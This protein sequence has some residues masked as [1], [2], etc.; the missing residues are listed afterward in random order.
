MSVTTRLARWRPTRWR[1][2]RPGSWPNGPDGRPPYPA[3]WRAVLRA[4]WRWAVVLAG[5]AVLCVIPSVVAAVPV[6]G[7]AVSAAALRHRILASAGL[8]YEGYAET[9][10]NAGLPVLPDLGNVSRLLDGVTDQYVWYRSPAHW[11]ADTLTTAGEDDVYQVG[12]ETFLWNHAY[13]LLTRVVGAQPVRLPR[14]SDL[15]PPALARRLLRLAAPGDHLSRL[16]S[17]RIAGVDAAGLRL[18]PASPSTTVSAI[19][20]WADPASGL[21]VEVRIFARGSRHPLLVSNFLQ[22]ARHRAALA[23]LVPHPAPGIDEVTASESTLNGLLNGGRRHPWPPALGG[24]RFDPAP[25]GNF[26]GVAFYGSG[27][28]R[29]ALLPLPGR[30]GRRVVAAATAVGAAGFSAPDGSGLVV[31]TPLLTVVLATSRRFGGFTFLLAGPVTEA[32]LERAAGDLL[33]RIARLH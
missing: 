16:P 6:P 3:R 14:A 20:I 23:T 9:T 33:G 29:L 28:A 21:P 18:V 26:L 10:A 11:R 1:P 22:V 27:F 19:D 13:N 15:L 2:A 31:R 17:R 12:P 24:F 7:S 30:T 32:A 5:A 25:S 4:R 8:P